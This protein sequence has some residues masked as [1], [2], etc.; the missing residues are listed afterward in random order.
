H[1]LSFACEGPFD[2]FFRS[3]TQSRDHL[4]SRPERSEHCFSRSSEQILYFSGESDFQFFLFTRASQVHT[5]AEILLQKTRET[6]L[7]SNGA[8]SEIRNVFTFFLIM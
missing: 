5:V 8:V 7:E 6:L 3:S 2:I 4:V 1:L